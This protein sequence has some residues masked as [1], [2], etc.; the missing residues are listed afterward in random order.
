MKKFLLLSV[1]FGAIVS[2]NCTQQEGPYVS[3]FNGKDLS[4]WN[5]GDEAGFEVIN[6][7]IYTGIFKKVKKAS[8]LYSKNFYGNYILR[9]EYLLSEKGNSGVLIRCNPENAWTTGVELQLLYPTTQQRDDLHCTGSIYGHVAVTT[10]PDETPLVWHKMGIK[11]D[12]QLITISVDDVVVTHVDVDTVESMKD[13]LVKGAIGFQVNHATSENQYAKFRNIHIR[14]LDAEPDY[15]VKGFY[16]KNWKYWAMALIS[17][18]N[19]GVDMVPLLTD[20]MSGND[21]IAKNGAKQALFDI[22]AK[23]SDPETSEKEK[24]KVNSALKKSIKETEAE[25]TSNY[26]KW[27]SGLIMSTNQ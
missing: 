3:L 8:D 14:D 19:I 20:L 13:K 26:L 22:V 9:L 6:G 21:P 2:F 16:Y 23:A 4:Q 18:V 7:E 12:R 11:C 25:I 10:R 15:V 5:L 17:A 27:L 24:N 1:L